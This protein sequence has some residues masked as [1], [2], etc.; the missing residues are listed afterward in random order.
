MIKYD[1]HVP[2]E[3]YGFIGFSEAETPEQALEA[4]KAIQEVVKPRPVNELPKKE[5]N[6]VLDIYLKTEQIPDGADLYEKMSPAQQDLIQAI[7]RSKKRTR[8]D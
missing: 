3:M 2:V 1:G 4:Y 6:E 7:K 8:E 5:F